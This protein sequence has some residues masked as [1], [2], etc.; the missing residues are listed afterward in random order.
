MSESAADESRPGNLEWSVCGA[1]VTGSQHISRGLGCDDAF[2]YGVTG[3][4]VIAAVADGAGSVTGTSAWGSH[5]ACQT[6]VQAAM[7]H[8]FIAKFYAAAAEDGDAIA[9]WLFDSALTRIVQQA[10]HLGLPV[11]KLATTLCIA[12]A[13]PGLAVFAQIGDGIIA[14]EDSGGI[15]TLLIEDKDEYANTTWFLQSN[16]AFEKAFRT[17]VRGD[18]TA[19]ALSTDGMTYKITNVV[20]GEAYAPFFQGAWQSVR[21]NADAAD[22]AALLR[23][24]QDDQTGDDKSMVLAVLDRQEDTFFPSGRPI[25]RTTVGSPAPPIPPRELPPLGDVRVDSIVSND[26][27]EHRKQ[28]VSGRRRRRR[29]S[30]HSDR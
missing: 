2:A 27:A 30:G 12:L 29:D 19:F 4:Y 21:T 14:V 5:I 16:E 8:E 11:P 25:Q 6:V 18:V 13:R 1:S 24:I 17:E 20:T 7:G 26:P 28:P 3:H 23:G 9:R 10:G 22:F 15:S